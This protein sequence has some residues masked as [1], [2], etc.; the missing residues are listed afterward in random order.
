MEK[1]V[2]VVVV[3]VVGG[4]CICVLWKRSDYDCGWYGDG[5]D[6]GGFSSGNGSVGGVFDCSC[7]GGGCGGDG[8]GCGGGD[9]CSALRVLD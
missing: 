5:C 8:S 3:V 2:M 7:D 6:C 4:K 1:V 9:G